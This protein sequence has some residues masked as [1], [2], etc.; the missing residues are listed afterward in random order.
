MEAIYHPQG[1]VANLHGDVDDLFDATG[2]HDTQHMFRVL[3][4]QMIV[5]VDYG[6]ARM[7][8]LMNGSLEHGLGVKVAERKRD[9]CLRCDHG[10]ELVFV[11]LLQH[12]LLLIFHAPALSALD[13]PTDKITITFLFSYV[14]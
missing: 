5:V 8:D 6:I 9:V 12:D 11:R 2:V 3:C 7:M 13:V 4:V 1:L 10:Y 14:Y